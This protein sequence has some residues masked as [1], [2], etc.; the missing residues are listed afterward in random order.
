MSRRKNRAAQEELYDPYESYNNKKSQRQSQQQDNTINFNSYLKQKR[1]VQL[2]PKSENQHEYIYQLT[3][4]STHIVFATGPAGAGKTFIAMLAAI[5]ALREGRVEKIILTRPA[6]GVD[7]EKHGFLPGDLTE[8]M[9]PWCMPLLAILKEY[10]SVPEVEKMIAD[11][12]IEICPI[13]FMRGRT[14][15]KA[16]VI[17]DEAQNCSINQVKAILTRIGEG[18]K[19]VVTGDL[20][21][22]DKKYSSDNGLRDFID[23]LKSE[24]SK[25]ISLVEFKHEDI[26]RH[27]AVKEVLRLYGED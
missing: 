11:E 6:V 14:L 17:I 26:Q 18:T 4:P 3:D 16:F 25:M 21:Q 27:P 9:A 23:R 7:D 2:T 19:M 15:S 24:G 5:K 10:Y 20:Q 12:V 13:A 22:H 1:T 8:K